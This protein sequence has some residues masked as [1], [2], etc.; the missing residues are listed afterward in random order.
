MDRN[1]QIAHAR[2]VFRAAAAQLGG[3]AARPSSYWRFSE[4]DGILEQL[5]LAVSQLRKLSKAPKA[6]PYA[7][8][9]EPRY[10]C[11]SPALVDLKTATQVAYEEKRAYERC[12]SGRNGKQD[13]DYAYVRGLE[14]IVTLADRGAK[15]ERIDALHTLLAL[16][17]YDDEVA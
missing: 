16:A 12:I 15:G 6:D 14:G 1:E 13:R 8:R 4:V 2:K 3:M 9:V 10:T 11:G 5:N 7:Y 17:D